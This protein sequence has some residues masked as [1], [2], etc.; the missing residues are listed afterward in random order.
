MVWGYLP[1][2]S[3]FLVAVFPESGL[4]WFRSFSEQGRR[5]VCTKRHNNS[6]IDS[7]LLLPGLYWAPLKNMGKNRITVLVKVM[8]ADPQMEIALLHSRRQE[9]KGSGE[10]L[11]SPHPTEMANESAVTSPGQHHGGLRL[12]TQ[13]AKNPNYLRCWPKPRGNMERR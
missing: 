10:S 11:V 12:L 1:S 4:H 5:F 9:Q 8:E 3:L 7:E 2:I 13:W 6:C